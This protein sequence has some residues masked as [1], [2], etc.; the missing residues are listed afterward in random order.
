MDRVGILERRPPTTR[1]R[2]CRQRRGQFLLCAPRAETH[3]AAVRR[4]RSDALG[5]VEN[6]AAALGEFEAGHGQ[7]WSHRA[8]EPP[9]LDRAASSAFAESTSRLRSRKVFRIKLRHGRLHTHGRTEVERVK[10][11]VELVTPHVAQRTRAV[12]GESAPERRHDLR[13]RYGRMGAADQSPNPAWAVRACR[14]RWRRDQNPPG[15]TT[16]AAGVGQVCTVCTPPM[17]RPAPIRGRGGCPRRP[18]PGCPFA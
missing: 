11:C 7:R 17:S 5:A 13:G 6:T 4:S 10:R 8:V 15:E 12:V 18:A 16:A 14:W 3:R 1:N 2:F 9:H